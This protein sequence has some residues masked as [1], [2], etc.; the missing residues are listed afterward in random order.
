MGCPPDPYE[1]SMNHDSNQ[2]RVLAE[3]AGTFLWQLNKS[4]SVM[5]ELISQVGDDKITIEYK[6][7]LALLKKEAAGIKT[8][9]MQRQ[10]TWDDIPVDRSNQNNVNYNRI[11]EHMQKAEKKIK[12]L[13]IILCKTRNVLLKMYRTTQQHITE[14]LSKKLEEEIAFHLD[15]RKDDRAAKLKVLKKRVA[16][17][18][19]FLKK[20]SKTDKE[21]KFY[22]DQVK[23]SI[24][25]IERI[26]KLTDDELLTNR[27]IF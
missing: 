2:T 6:S 5:E 15:H 8:D 17:G 7:T 21:Y 27:E 16:E 25:E 10:F 20:L 26:S 14:E 24:S 23:S 4:F 13:E 3:K 9:G 19:K 11:S 22:D 12:E 1:V 18:E